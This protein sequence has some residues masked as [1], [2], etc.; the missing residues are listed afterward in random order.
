MSLVCRSLCIIQGFCSVRPLKSSNEC[1]AWSFSSVPSLSPVKWVMTFLPLL[2][3]FL[4]NSTESYGEIQMIVVSP[5][6]C[7][8][9]PGI[10]MGIG[11][12]APLRN[13]WRRALKERRT[14]TEGKI[15]CASE[16]P[17]FPWALCLMPSFIRKQWKIRQNGQNGISS[18]HHFNKTCSYFTF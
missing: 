3:G 9:S 2:L 18:E 12:K 8:L 13:S 15:Q 5:A 1:L 6:K 11:G 16:L 7:I 10:D 4:W 14:C 17:D